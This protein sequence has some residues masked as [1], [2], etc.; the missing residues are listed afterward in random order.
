MHDT[1]RQTE[2]TPCTQYVADD[3]PDDPLSKLRQ[4]FRK[5]KHDVVEAN[6]E[7]FGEL[8]TAQHPKVGSLPR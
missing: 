7:K 6:P 8:A 3:H 1:I 5:F 4:G 2:S